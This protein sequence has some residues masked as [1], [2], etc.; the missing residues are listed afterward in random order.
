MSRNGE[1]A[2]C[3]FDTFLSLVDFSAFGMNLGGLQPFWC[4]SCLE[5]EDFEP[6]WEIFTIVTSARCGAENRD[7]D[8]FLRCLA[9]SKLQI[10]VLKS[11]S[12]SQILLNNFWRK[13]R[14]RI[15]LLRNA[16][17][18]RKKLLMKLMTKG[19]V[20][21]VRSILFLFL[22]FYKTLLKPK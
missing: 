8:L 7:L 5:S 9:W 4:R 21:G 20:Q 6:V 15:T 11:K 17:G 18:F 12:K 1:K 3:K 10:I 13:S 19:N 14:Q 22:H 2:T 16:F